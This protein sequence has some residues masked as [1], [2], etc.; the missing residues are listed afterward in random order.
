MAARQERI[1]FCGCGAGWD[2]GEDR[3]DGTEQVDRCVDHVAMQIEH[4]AP[5]TS[6]GGVF[7]PPIVGCGTPT[8]PTELV[9]KHLTEA[10][11]CDNPSGSHVL[12]VESAVLED[13][14]DHTGGAGCLDNPERLGAVRGQ[15]LVD[16]HRE[17]RVNTLPGLPRVKAAG[18]GQD[19][20]IQA[21]HGQ[22]GVEVVGYPSPWHL[23]GDLRRALPIG[24]GDR[25]DRHRGLLQE[26]C[27][28][29][30]P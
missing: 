18:S 28:D 3:V 5:T 1:I 26:R 16:D 30:P 21:S 4:D 15:R 20:E 11:R 25:S 24:G 14:Q 7:T 10:A 27:M 19:N 9:T 22:Q 6:R 23:L 17:P 8:F 2:L 13:R 29:T 12:G